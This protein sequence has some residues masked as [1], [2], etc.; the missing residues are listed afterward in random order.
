MVSNKI[1]TLQWR[2]VHFTSKSAMASYLYKNM[3]PLLM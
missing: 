2:A 1:S 3:T